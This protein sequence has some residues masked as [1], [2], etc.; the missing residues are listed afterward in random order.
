MRPKFENPLARNDTSVI[1]SARVLKQWTR[2]ILALDNDDIVTVNELACALPGCPPKETIILVLLHQGETL[3]IPI[4][5]AMR[6]VTEN[7]IASAFIDLDVGRLTDPSA[8]P[9][10][11][12]AIQHRD[13]SSPI[14]L[15]R[16]QR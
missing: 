15:S 10:E 6:E 16:P 2:E 11:T 3:K 4:H 8:K 12:N 13:A 1:A 5:K 7:D 9:S 14:P